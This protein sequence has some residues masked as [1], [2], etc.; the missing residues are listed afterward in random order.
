MAEEIPSS[1]MDKWMDF[2]RL[3][4]FGQQWENWLMAV[5]TSAFAQV[6]AKKGSIV[7][8][9]DYFYVDEQTK[10]EE[11]LGSLL[12]LFDSKVTNG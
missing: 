4:P 7:K 2:Y 12:S 10:E 1:V 3:E 6:H 9:N 8:M 5:P 11:K